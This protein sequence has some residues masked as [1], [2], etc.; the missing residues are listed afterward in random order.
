MEAPAL[1]QRPRA[2]IRNSERQHALKE[3]IRY[4][5]P[6]THPIIRPVRCGLWP[7]HERLLENNYF[8]FRILFYCDADGSVGVYTEDL[9]VMCP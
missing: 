1:P 7:V 2:K 5:W 6:V 8:I 4:A 3:C 9:R